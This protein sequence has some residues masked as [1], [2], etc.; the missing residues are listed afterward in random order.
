MFEFEDEH[1]Y[2]QFKEKLIISGQ[3]SALFSSWAVNENKPENYIGKFVFKFLK[4]L[5]IPSW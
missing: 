4:L 2:Y 3:D 5:P 1:Y